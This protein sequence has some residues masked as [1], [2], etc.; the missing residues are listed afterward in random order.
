MLPAMHSAIARPKIV[1]RAT[2]ARSSVLNTVEKPT[3]S[4]H[5]LS[6]QIWVKI[7]YEITTPATM[8]TVGR[9]GDRRARN[10]ALTRHSS[11]A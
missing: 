9:N 2:R 3:A 10:I 5:S 4:N 11:D 6:V 7:R 8:A 1:N